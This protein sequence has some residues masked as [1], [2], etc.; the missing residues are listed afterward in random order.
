MNLATIGDETCWGKIVIKI[1]G[2]NQN[3]G[4]FDQKKKKLLNTFS[5]VRAY[6]NRSGRAV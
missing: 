5:G 3:V 2:A 1:R 6:G 4:E